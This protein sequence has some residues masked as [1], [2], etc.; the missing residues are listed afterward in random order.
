MNKNILGV[1]AFP[2]ILFLL[3]LI[4]APEERSYALRERWRRLI[5]DNAQ[6]CLDYERTFLTVPDSARLISSESE[7]S[8]FFIIYKAKDLYGS[9]SA[10]NGIC[11]FIGNKVDPDMSARLF[12]TLVLDEQHK[13]KQIRNSMWMPN[14]AKY[15]DG[16]PPSSACGFGPSY[17][18]VKYNTQLAHVLP[19]SSDE[20]KVLMVASAIL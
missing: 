10:M 16:A 19:P 6:A 18:R 11:K 13:C 1:V 17:G 12:D 7:N 8:I 3:Y 4:L 2:C 15:R 9:Y 5:S 20:E 14:E